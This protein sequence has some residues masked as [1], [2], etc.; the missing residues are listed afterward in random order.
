LHYL[1]NRYGPA[2]EQDHHSAMHYL[3]VTERYSA[4]GERFFGALFKMAAA[5]ER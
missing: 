4:A 3:S 1:D 5:R 2:K